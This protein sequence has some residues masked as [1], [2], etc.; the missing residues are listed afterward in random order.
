[1]KT[2]GGANALFFSLTWDFLK[3]YLPKQAGHSP[4]TVESYRDSLTLF[5]R[6]LTDGQHKSLAKFTFS[7]CTKECIFG[8]RDCLQQS[9][10]KPSTINVR[11]AAIRTYLNYAAGR[12]IS[13]QSAALSISLISSTLSK[14]GK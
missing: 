6:F 9:G 12:D 1:M 13:V 5:R 3:E 11:I 2:K 14:K 4:A 10:N 8:F 7:D